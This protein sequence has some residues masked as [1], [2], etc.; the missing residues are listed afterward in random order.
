MGNHRAFSVVAGCVL[1]EKSA[2]LRYARL[3]SLR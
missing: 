3:L 1:D 2:V